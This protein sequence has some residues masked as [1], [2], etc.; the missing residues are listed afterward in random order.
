MPKKTNSAVIDSVVFMGIG[1]PL[2]NFI[3]LKNCLERLVK[4]TFV[5]VGRI[6]LSTCGL[7]HGIM[8]LHTLADSL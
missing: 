8:Q 6:A 1:E 3:N 5:K 4:D 2:D 7:P